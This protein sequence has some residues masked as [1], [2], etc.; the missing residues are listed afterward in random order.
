MQMPRRFFFLVDAVEFHPP[1]DLSE[2]GFQA[3][4]S[5][6]RFSVAIALFLPIATDS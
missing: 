5:N 4:F 3:F 6:F 1:P 2:V